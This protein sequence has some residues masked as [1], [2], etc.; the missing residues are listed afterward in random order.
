MS[1]SRRTSMG[2][3]GAKRCSALRQHSE[4]PDASEAEGR[5]DPEVLALH[6]AAY[7]AARRQAGREKPR[8]HKGEPGLALNVVFR[9]VVRFV[10]VLFCLLSCTS[11]PKRKTKHSRDPAKRRLGPALAPRRPRELP[12]W[13]ST[14]LR[15]SGTAARTMGSLRQRPGC[16]S[17]P[18]RGSLRQVHRGLLPGRAEVE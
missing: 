18:G 9:C 12:P 8:K 6:R 11:L 15:S 4:S 7:T 10:F 3:V 13:K 5:A 2:C 1:Q 17:C 14:G 16:T